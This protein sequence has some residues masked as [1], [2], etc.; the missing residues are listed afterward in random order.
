M[1]DPDNNVID[2]QHIVHL[3]EHQKSSGLTMANKVTKQ[4]VCF[5]KNKMRVKYAVQVLSRSVANALLTVNEM[6]IP[7]FENVHATVKCFDAIFDVMN[8]KTIPIFR[9]TR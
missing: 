6:N 8:S 4:H 9:T 5:E 1:I 3:Y 2:W 7:G